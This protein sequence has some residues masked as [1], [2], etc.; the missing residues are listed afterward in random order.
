MSSL[1][2]AF[3][4]FELLDDVVY[5]IDNKD[6]L[7]KLKKELDSDDYDDLDNLEMIVD[8]NAE[9][10][11]DLQDS[12]VGQ[13]LLLCPSC[14]TIH[15]AKK[16]DIIENEETP[17]FV[18][19]GEQCP[20]CDATEGFEIV[21]EVAPYEDNESEDQEVETEEETEIEDEFDLS[22][23]DDLEDEDNFK[24][25]LKRG[26][27]KSILERLLDGDMTGSNIDENGRPLELEGDDDTIEEKVGSVLPRVKKQVKEHKTTKATKKS[28]KESKGLKEARHIYKDDDGEIQSYN[29]WGV[30]YIETYKDK[31]VIV[32]DEFDED[33]YTIWS[34][35]WNRPLSR[36]RQD[37]SLEP[38]WFNSIEEVKQYIDNRDK[39][40]NLDE[41]K[42]IEKPVYSL[43]PR[44]DSR[45]SFYGKAQVDT[46]DKND[47]NKL[48]SYDTL[49]AEIKDGKPVVYGTYSQTTL[50][51]I[52]DW[53]KQNGFKAENSKQILADY[54]VKDESC[55]EAVEDEE[56]IIKVDPNKPKVEIEKEDKSEVGDPSHPIQKGIKGRVNKLENLE[57][58]KS[59]KENA[60]D[61]YADILDRAKM[62][63]DDNYDIDEAIWDAIDNGLIY[64]DDEFEVVK[65]LFSP[66]ELYTAEGE[67]VSTYVMERIF[68]EIYGEVSDYYDEK[69]NDVEVEESLKKEHRTL[70]Q[71]KESI[72]SKLDKCLKESVSKEDDIDAKDD[73]KKE[74]AKEKEEKAIDDADADK[75]YEEDELDESLFDNLI[76]KYCTRVYENVKDYR[77]HNGYTESGKLVLEG[78]ITYK[79]GKTANT[80]FVFEKRMVKDNQVKYVG[81]NETFS[82]SKKAFALN[83]KVDNKKIISESLTYNYRVKV[84][85]SKKVVYG[86]I[87]NN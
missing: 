75:D 11:E 48:Y 49:V 76:N 9:D 6:E 83:C 52:K 36:F 55:K 24:E 70:D 85:D 33:K 56:T 80:K 77:T 71:I 17:E 29:D 42:L 30:N 45:K 26:K 64:T 23:E 32:Q 4:E 16:E 67:P 12:Y 81:L 35:S 61:V 57:E 53:L 21:G 14:H 38:I 41:S 78:I 82:K 5:D 18:N 46:G 68:N 43:N 40:E 50:R 58:S 10:E 37:N 47:Q 73:D 20:H 60:Q 8:V 28:L 84:D 65:D 15:Y 51:H 72:K 62:N 7:D 1:K 44:Y 13:L 25:N 27:Q 74:V 86:S 69:H 39:N 19:V 34:T 22:G 2:E 59:L 63:I 54:G 66:N 3:E 31:A 87:K 79:S